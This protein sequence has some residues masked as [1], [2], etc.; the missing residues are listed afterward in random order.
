MHFGQYCIAGKLSRGK[1]FN[2]LAKIRFS[3]R[4]LSR[5][6]RWC[7]CQKMPHPPISWRK[8]SRIATKFVSFLPRKFPTVTMSHQLRWGYREMEISC[9]E[10]S[11]MAG[12]IQRVGRSSSKTLSHTQVSFK[13]HACKRNSWLNSEAKCLS[14]N[15]VGERHLCTSIKYQSLHTVLPA[16][17]QTHK[18]ILTMAA[19]HR[20]VFVAIHFM[21]KLFAVCQWCHVDMTLRFRPCYSDN[22]TFSIAY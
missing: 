8:L 6:A 3:W 2:N 21:P 1:T 7:R 18:S 17:S 10:R 4:K 9:P 14:K 11:Q 12:L 16:C 22:T 5:I 15:R 19:A 13:D 20:T